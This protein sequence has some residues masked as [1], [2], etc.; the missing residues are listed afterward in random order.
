MF[1]VCLESCA[2]A[3]P[4]ALGPPQAVVN[5]KWKGLSTASV[6]SK[7]TKLPAVFHRLCDYGQVTAPLWASMSIEY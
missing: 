5:I 1:S 2:G 3:T 4:P 7:C 6:H